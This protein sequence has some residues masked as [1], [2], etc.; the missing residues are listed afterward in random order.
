MSSIAYITDKKMIEYHRINGNRNINF[1]KPSNA[2][3]ISNFK[4]GDFLFFLAKGTEKGRQ[5]EKGIIGYG[6][7]KKNHILSF[8]QMWA[9]YGHRNGYPTKELLE[10]AIQK[11]TKNHKTPEFLSC[12]ELED[13]T[14]FQAPI[15][16]SEIGLQISNKIES[17]IYLDKENMLNTSKILEVANQV[18]VDMWSGL[19]HEKEESLLIKDTQV[20]MI[21][22]IS[23]KL[24]TEIFTN[25][26]I[27]RIQ[28]FCQ[29]FI[30]DHQ[31]MICKTE[32]ID[33]QKDNIIIYLPCLV[34]TNDFMLKFQYMIGHYICYQ[35]Y[36]VNIEYAKEIEVRLIFN[37]L[38][39][40]DIK[41]MLNNSGIKHKEKLDN[42]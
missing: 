22:N 37:Q 25:Y 14:F 35:S 34:N 42:D 1:W 12:F 10:D 30:K 21:T 5:R 13:V 41:K 32:W 17:F 31:R 29:Q 8:K 19:F 33:I 3:K 28:K 23:E 26:D 27:S 39:G 11:L 6:K 18:G 24:K 16:L 4:E 20:N 9:K 7:L 15:Y 38:L 40:E 2:K 36:I